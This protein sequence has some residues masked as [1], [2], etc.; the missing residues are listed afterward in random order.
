MGLNLS[1]GLS[2]HAS[3]L[4][5]GVR[6]TRPSVPRPALSVR[7]GGPEPSIALES[8]EHLVEARV[9]MARL[10]ARCQS[11][12]LKPGLPSGPMMRRD[13]G[14]VVMGQ[15]STIVVGVWNG[16]H[17]CYRFVSAQTRLCNARCVS[18]QAAGLR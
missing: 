14:N 17:L 5:A 3:R 9:A 12:A 16:P 7:L 13:F 15:M 11:S 6:V 2:L 8:A 1:A 10:A 4:A 18:A